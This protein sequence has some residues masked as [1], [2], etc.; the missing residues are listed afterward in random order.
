M[1]QRDLSRGVFAAILCAVLGA[2]SLP[3]AAQQT[4]RL[5]PR[6]T[7]A[8]ADAE[9]R[10]HSHSPDAR[11]ALREVAMHQ[12]LFRKRVGRYATSLR[13]LGYTPVAG[14]QV[15][16]TS[17]GPASYAAV[18]SYRRSECALFSG[19]AR[20]PRSYARQPLAVTCRS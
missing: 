15:S 10:P 1:K 2:I 14:V 5:P 6:P 13:E 3:A 18:A 17:E 11:L 4:P 16:L 20:P 9:A 19:S 8:G 7:G 12:A